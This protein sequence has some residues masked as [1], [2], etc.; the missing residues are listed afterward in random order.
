MDP[1]NQEVWQYHVDIA[2][3]AIGWGFDEI[4]LD[5]VRFPSDGATS[6]MIFPDWSKTTSTK[7]E[8][9]R[10][11]FAYYSDHLKDEPAYLSA[12][13]FGL[14]TTV[15]N[16]MNIGQL[17]ENAAPY[18]DYICPMV[19]PSHYPTE[20]M[21]FKNP[22]DHPYE[23]IA[24]AI[25]VGNKRLAST[26]PDRAQLRPWIQDFNLGAMYTADMIKQEIKAAGDNGADG[27]LVW[28][29]KNLY[30]WA[31]LQK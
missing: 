11:F 7:P 28:D 13:L 14:T 20:Y 16:D 23:V 2:K 9:I 31:A 29:P 30:T 27:F 15:R 12:D 17:L 8:V 10:N 22:A 18:F 24:N 6:N 4:N 3:E 1:D 5:Y 19:Y 25:K 26:T 21:K